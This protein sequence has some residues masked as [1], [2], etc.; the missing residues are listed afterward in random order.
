MNLH[1]RVS[2]KYKFVNNTAR[3]NANVVTLLGAAAIIALGALASGSSFADASFSPKT[4][5]VRAAE[6]LEFQ[7]INPKIQMAAAYGDRSKGSH[8]S[9]GKFPANFSTPP[10]THTGAYHGVVIQGVMTNPFEG[11]AN[12]PKMSPGSYWYVP[13]GSTHTTACV[14]AIPCQFYFHA[15]SNFDFHPVGQ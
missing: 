13:A 1:N 7:N 11:E 15:D 3:R 12:P 6:T 14:S 5:V 2:N 4:E 8:G 10:H 9:F